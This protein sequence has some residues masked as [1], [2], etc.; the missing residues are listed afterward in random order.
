VA[1]EHVP[2]A[3]AGMGTGSHAGPAAVIDREGEG[4]GTDM[5]SFLRYMAQAHICPLQR[6]FS[7][8]SASDT[9][10]LLVQMLDSCLPVCDVLS[11]TVQ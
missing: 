4:S 7:I 6:I 8:A 1:E 2:L 3:A 11:Y 10:G 9:L 5:H